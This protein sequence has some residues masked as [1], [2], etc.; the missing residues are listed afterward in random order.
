MRR[1]DPPGVRLYDIPRDL[2]ARSLPAYRGK[3]RQHAS[4]LHCLTCVRRCP[5]GGRAWWCV[6]LRTTS[7]FLQDLVA[8]RVLIF[9]HLVVQLAHLR[10]HD[11]LQLVELR[12]CSLLLAIAPLLVLVAHLRDGVG[13]DGMGWDGMGWDGMG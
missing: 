7:E 13:W 1:A 10:F 9:L 5:R 8:Q 4:L 6:V 12:V 11:A 2:S 3:V